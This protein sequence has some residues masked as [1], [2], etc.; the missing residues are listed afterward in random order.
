MKHGLIDTSKGV[1]SCC[2]RHL[3]YGME[4]GRVSDKGKVY[5][6]G[7]QNGIIMLTVLDNLVSRLGPIRVTTRGK[8][9]VFVEAIET[10]R[11]Y[12]I[13]SDEELL[14]V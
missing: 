2:W 14:E 9:Q 1:V 5:I 10:G 12:V 13:D 4:A 8:K 6:V 11:I 7:H 3:V